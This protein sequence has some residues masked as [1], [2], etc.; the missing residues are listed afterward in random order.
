MSDPLIT[1]EAVADFD[2]RFARALKDAGE[3]A[4]DLRVPLNLIRASWFRSNN[5]IF[6]LSGRG[7]Y[8]DLSEKYKVFKQKEA[9][10]IYP[11]LKFGGDLASSITNPSDVNAIGK[12]VVSTGLLSSTQTLLVGTK[13]PYG[14]YHQ[15]TKDRKV[16]PRRPFLFAGAEQVAPSPINKRIEIWI[17]ILEEWVTQVTGKVGSKK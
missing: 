9:G 3:K 7:Q 12:V 10:F 14:V 11:I 15:S 6:A 1:I 17:T 8:D 13:V 5:A 2:T 4:K 16:I